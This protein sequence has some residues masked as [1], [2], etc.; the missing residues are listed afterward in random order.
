MW[1]AM[2]GSFGFI[3]P[4]E[5][6]MSD[7][8]CLF[9]RIASGQIP[10]TIVFQDEEVVA[11]KDINPHAPVHIVL[12]PRVHLAGLNEL[13]P[14][15]APLVG[16][17]ALVARSLAAELGIAESGYRFLSNCGPDAGQSV[18]HLHFH[19]LGGQHMGSKLA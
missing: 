19:L 7:P 17:L 2:L 9:C 3:V 13:T 16:R 10:A 1:N 18:A 12:V 11:F 4:E 8:Q 6:V 5:P 15:L 14:E